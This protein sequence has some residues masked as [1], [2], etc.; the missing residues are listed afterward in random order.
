VPKNGISA[1]G[2]WNKYTFAAYPGKLTTK[3]WAKRAKVSPDTVARDIKDLVD[4]NVLVPQQG[5]VCDVH[6]DIYCNYS[7]LFVPMPVKVE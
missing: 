3:N 4:K 2:W 6:Y 5:R 1:V 7:I